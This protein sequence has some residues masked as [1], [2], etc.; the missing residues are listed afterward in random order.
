M[1][2]IRFGVNLLGQQVSGKRIP[3]QVNIHLTDKCNLRCSH[4]YIDFA[5]GFGYYNS[6]KAIQE[7][8]YKISPFEQVAESI[9]ANIQLL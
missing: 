6:D 7:L 9:K 8:G 4:C 1:N 2:L 3:F 5:A